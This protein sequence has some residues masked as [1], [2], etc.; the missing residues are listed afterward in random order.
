MSEGKK[1][2]VIVGGGIAGLSAGIYGKLAGYDVEI[3]EKN[4][5]AGGQC[6]GWNRKGC[7]I[8][9]CIHWLT[10]TK[11]GTALRNVWETV[12]ALEKNTK[13]VDS[14]SFY[15]SITG[16]C[17]VT[18]WKDLKR[19][20]TELL[21]LSP[22]DETEIRKFAE[23]VRYAAKCE[24]PAEKPMDA[25]GIMDY[26][27][28]GASMTDM[29]KVMR[30]Y[31]SIDLQ[32][33]AGRF[34]HPALRALFT[35]YL[36]KEYIA[37]SFLVSY[38]SIV[39]GN[40]EIPK[41]GSLAM[42]NRM[43]QRF[44]ELGGKL[45]CNT[46]VSRIVIRNKKVVGIETA[47]Q[48]EVTADYV[49][50]SVDTMEMFEKLVGKEYMDSKWQSCYSDSEKYP[51]FSA[52]QAAFVVDAEAYDKKGTIFF[53]CFP[54]ET[55]GKKIDRISVKS[56]EYES[57][58][59]PAGKVVLQVN[60]PQFDQEYFYW[61]RLSRTEYKSQKEMAASAVEE[62][63][64]LQ[65]PKLRGHMEFLDCW[66]PLTYERYCNA[67][68]GAYMSF[69]TRKGVKSFRVK[70]VVK[71]IKNLYIASQWIMAPGGLPVA[72]TAG[73]FAIWRIV[74]KEKSVRFP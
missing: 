1:K 30:E 14:D 38:G 35:D 62:R 47:D 55:G 17:R 56:Y 11:K 69:I 10:G 59:A 25:M 15:T 41:G 70:G 57:D 5:V 52:V 64:L 73:K 43:V 46:P 18:L 19:T 53:D 12:G 33:M 2:I 63:L 34:R 45:Y 21:R 58:F 48:K 37:S 8:D 3:Y 27:H 31:G 44:Q 40:G 66:T 65:F 67:Y 4:P 72:V 61:K 39:S 22:E 60:V 9:N 28:M 68:H 29:P 26:I 16:D 49:I 23:H 36:P 71:G 20:E 42:V 51:L 32:E 6:M 13:F 50:S 24:I 74:R 54:F 7:H